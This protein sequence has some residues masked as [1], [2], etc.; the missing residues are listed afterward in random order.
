[1]QMHINIRS[2]G[3]E[4]GTVFGQQ[5]PKRLLALRQIE[6]IQLLNKLFLGV[7]GAHYATTRIGVQPL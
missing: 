5:G 7:H 2:P 6:R 3:G 1:M 4:T